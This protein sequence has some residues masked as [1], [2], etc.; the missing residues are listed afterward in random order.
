VEEDFGGLLEAAPD[1][2]I[3][4]GGDGRIRLVN[5]QRE[6]LC[7]YRREELLTNPH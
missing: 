2:M 1:A 3:V 4:V 6:R 5:G 7:G